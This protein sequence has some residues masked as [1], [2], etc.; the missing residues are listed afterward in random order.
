MEIFPQWAVGA[1]ALMLFGALLLRPVHPHVLFTDS[2][3]F[4]VGRK[5]SCFLW[6]VLQ[7]A[8]RA[9]GRARRKHEQT[10]NG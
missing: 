7:S 4:H 1:L 9:V 5:H 3:V 8:T 6:P 10:F 2:T